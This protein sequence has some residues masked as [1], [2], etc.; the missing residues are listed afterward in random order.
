[1][2]STDARLSVIPAGSTVPWPAELLSSTRFAEFVR[3]VSDVY[4]LIVFDSAPLLSVVDT[5]ELAKHVDGIAM[6]VRSD[7]TTRDQLRSASEALSRLPSRPTG[8]VATGVSR[9]TEGEYGYYNYAYA[10]AS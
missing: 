4:D 5:L 9:A 1:M 3:D 6:C 8:L 2:P 10:A 7:Q